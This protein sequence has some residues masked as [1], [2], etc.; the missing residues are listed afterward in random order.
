M[1][2]FNTLRF[3]NEIPVD[4]ENMDRYKIST[5][6]GENKLTV[7][8]AKSKDSGVFKCRV[9]NDVG[10]TSC[11]AKLTVKG[12]FIKKCHTPY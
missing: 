8:R 4:P 2:I 10:W 7:I 3:R 1:M 5:L 11:D 9:G 6:K 12:R